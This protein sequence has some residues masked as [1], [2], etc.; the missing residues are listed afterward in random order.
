MQ[1]YNC[2]IISDQTFLFLK[3]LF[4]IVLYSNSDYLMTSM[5]RLRNYIYIREGC[6]DV[7]G[8]R[9]NGEKLESVSHFLGSEK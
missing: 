3:A 7:V 8:G 1:S 9:C 2:I 4:T 5:L 6:G